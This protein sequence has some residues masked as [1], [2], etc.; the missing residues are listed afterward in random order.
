MS[1]NYFDI[2]IVVIFLL[3]TYVGYR[4]GFFISL[5]GFLRY[6]I[7]IPLCFGLSNSLSTPVYENYV[8]QKALESISQNVANTT[9]I[10]E[11]SSNLQSSINDLPPF[12]TS[13]VDTSFL[14]VTSDDVAEAILVNVFEPL[15][16]SIV[17]L[18][19]F[20]LTFILFFGATR[21]IMSIINRARRKRVHKKQKSIITKADSLFGCVFGFL[22]SF[23][24]VLAI[25]S[26]LMYILN[27]NDIVFK[28]SVISQIQN[29]KLISVV[30]EFNPLNYL[31]GG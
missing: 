4:R 10:D 22:K 30:N 14:N 26:I 7:G 13:N 6:T 16:I 3:F 24:I 23:V 31:F 11:V 9:N 19:I 15:L 18:V 1:I 25:A 5:L 21:I 17:K 8:R 29:S 20:V 27:L 12:L 28:D 2:A